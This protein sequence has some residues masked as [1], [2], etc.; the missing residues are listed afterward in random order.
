MNTWKFQ[1]TIIHP[2]CVAKKVCRKQIYI[3]VRVHIVWKNKFQSKSILR[4]YYYCVYCIKWIILCQTFWSSVL[5][6][7]VLSL[8]IEWTIR[9]VVIFRCGSSS[10]FPGR[11]WFEY[12]HLNV[13]MVFFLLSSSS[14]FSLWMSFPPPCLQDGTKR[15]FFHFI[16]YHSSCGPD[17]IIW[18]SRVLL[19]RDVIHVRVRY[20]HIS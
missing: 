20:N 3:Y 13:C 12:L 8:Q 6:E 4:F 2:A 1:Q 7:F 10:F 19:P 18:I 14:F 5:V 11:T 16:R 17:S 15:S 9:F